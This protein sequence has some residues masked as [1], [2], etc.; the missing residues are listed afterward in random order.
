MA[1]TEQLQMIHILVAA[2][3]EQARLVLM[4]VV[5]LAAMVVLAQHHLF[6]AVP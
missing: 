3:E 5:E 6:L 1:E 2:A 4:A